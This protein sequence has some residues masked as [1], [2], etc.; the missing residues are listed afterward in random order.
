LQQS[1]GVGLWYWTQKLISRKVDL[2]E[3][4]GDRLHDLT[5][6]LHAWFTRNPR[7]T[8]LTLIITSALIDAICLKSHRSSESGPKRAVGT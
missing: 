2:G 6:P 8:N 1:L 7:A 5:T 4:V 3:G